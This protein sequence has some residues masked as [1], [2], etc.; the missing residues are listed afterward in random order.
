MCC[1]CLGTSGREEDLHWSEVGAKNTP[2]PSTT[3]LNSRL[4][5]WLAWCDT[6]RQ[7]GA[8]ERGMEN[9]EYGA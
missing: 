6:Y 5:K 4:R 7:D 2:E 3:T 9:K 8:G 1:G